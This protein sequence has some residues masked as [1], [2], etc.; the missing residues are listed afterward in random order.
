V[1]FASAFVVLLT[2]TAVLAAAWL[3]R[4]AVPDR[5]REAE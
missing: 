1:I 4:T 3:M 5:L 2:T